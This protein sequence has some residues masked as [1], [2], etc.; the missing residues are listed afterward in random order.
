MK[1]QALQKQTHSFFTG[2][3]NN[4]C[5][6]LSLACFFIT[7]KADAK[8]WSSHSSELEVYELIYTL[9][10][11]AELPPKKIKRGSYPLYLNEQARSS[12]PLLSAP[13]PI[14]SDCESLLK[15]IRAKILR[16]GYHLVY[17][18]RSPRPDGPLHFAIAKGNQAVMALRL[19]PT[20]SIATLLYHLSSTDELIRSD[21]R[22]LP[23]HL[24]LVINDQDVIQNPDL[25][26]WLKVEKREYLIKLDPL[27]I[28]RALIHPNSGELFTSV[29]ERAEAI[30]QFL[31]NLIKRAPNSVGFYIDQDVNLSLDRVML[32]QLIHICEKYNQILALSHLSDPLIHALA[33][34]AGVRSFQFN[35]L[36]KRKQLKNAL[37]S[38]EAQ[39]VIEGEINS[40]FKIAGIEERLSLIKWLKDLEDRQ[41][42]ILRLS[43]SAW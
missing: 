40:E 17:P 32:D 19:L 11:E 33:L 3:C 34:A 13:C 21:I 20:T 29:D 30:N 41:V 6:L 14:L 2:L 39:L 12:F 7:A 4:V 5:L 24:T 23:S 35:G 18:E 10:L 25:G 9:L 26:A 38:L 43:E 1:L 42:M 22:T 27:N 15:T 37:K 31:S 16:S 36:V 8:R 28:K